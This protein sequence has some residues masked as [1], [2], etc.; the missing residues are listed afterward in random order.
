ML[1]TASRAT[2]RARGAA[3]AVV[4]AAALVVGVSGAQSAVN[5]VSAGLETGNFS[6]FSQ[7]NATNGSIQVTSERAYSG[8]RSAKATYSGGGSNGYARGIGNV[9]WRDGDTVTYSAAFYLPNGFHDAMQ[10]QVSI[11]R[12]DN[13]GIAPQNTDRGGIAIFGNDKRAYLVRTRDGSEQVKLAGPI[14]LPEGRWFTLSVTQRFSTA[15]AYSE[16]RLDGRVVGT[17]S[18]R[19]HYGRAIDRMRVGIVAIAAGS[20]R[21][22]LTLYFDDA[23]IARGAGVPAPQTEPEPQ[24]NPDPGSERGVNQPPTVKI[25][26][27]ANKFRLRRGD[28]VVRARASD[29]RRVT[30]VRFYVNGKLR[31]TDRSAPYR[32]VWRN[33][34]R[35]LSRGTHTTTVRAFD[36]QGLQ[37]SDSVRIVKPRRR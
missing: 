10:G 23:R 34:R 29:D 5:P 11:L 21:N 18:T 4:L 9:G 32:W 36:D 33:A 15:D 22:P 31:S 19:N 17:S 28:L 13:Y 8:S 30:R 6:E 1:F 25:T 14:D 20:Q 26:S 12:W 35:S 16:V 24:P 2:A 7:H 3:A 37:A 27:P